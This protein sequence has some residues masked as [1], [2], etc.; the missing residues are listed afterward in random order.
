MLTL[1]LAGALS[2]YPLLF[3]P[4]LILLCAHA[5]ASQAHARG[6]EPSSS[7]SAYVRSA[8]PFQRCVDAYSRLDQRAD[9]TLLPNGSTQR[10]T[11]TRA[12]FQL[13]LSV[14]GV[15]GLS[16]FIA[17]SWA[18]VPRVYGVMCV[19]LHYLRASTNI[20]DLPSHPPFSFPSGAPA[21]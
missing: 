16:R 3:A 4:P 12:L 6:G 21:A 20:S 8:P 9:L 7:A 18:F 19:P 17:G 1:S 14:A 10:A 13:G 15:F 5:A 11:V 2:L